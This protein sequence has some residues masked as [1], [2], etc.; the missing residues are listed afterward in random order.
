MVLC[1]HQDME[2]SG[3]DVVNQKSRDRSR[4]LFNVQK[5]KSWLA[6]VSDNDAACRAH[7]LSHSSVLLSAQE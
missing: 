7:F 3:S 2:E 1:K 5:N 6:Y 4:T